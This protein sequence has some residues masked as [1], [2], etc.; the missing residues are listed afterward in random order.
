L[1]VATLAN[2]ARSGL[3][4]PS[5]YE[6]LPDDRYYTIESGWIVPA[7][8]TH[9]PVAGRVLEPCAGRGHLVAELRKRRI[10][11]VARDL[12]AH[13]DPLVADIETPVDMDTITSLAAFAWLITNPPFSKLDERVERLLRLCVRDGCNLALL[14]RQEWTAPEKRRAL[15]HDNPNFAGVIVLTARPR[16]IEDR[17]KDAPRH[18]FLWGVW[19]AVPRAAG[20]SP[21]LKFAGRRG[22]ANFGSERPDSGSESAP[23]P[24]MESAAAL[25]DS[26]AP[27]A[28]DEGLDQDILPTING[29]FEGEIVPGTFGPCTSFGATGCSCSLRLK[30]HGGSLFNVR[31]KFLT[32]GPQHVVLRDARALAAWVEAVGAP[33]SA[34]V[35]N[36]GMNLWI[37][38]RG[39]RLLFDLRTRTDHRG[40]PE[41]FVAHVRVDG[42]A[43]V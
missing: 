36:L 11:V 39:K 30:M 16:W 33:P 9:A 21:W 7:L 8:L 24:A 42:A 10:K 19:T 15:I 2:N 17:S 25:A 35:V 5:T 29:E 28:A 13:E 23:V 40:L 20:V 6:R 12:V 43:N 31:V 32:T 22:A 14:L 37:A 4:A 27:E 34:G 41:V 3:I 26:A 1:D 38:G 18:H